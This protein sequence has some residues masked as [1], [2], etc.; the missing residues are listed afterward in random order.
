MLIPTMQNPC[1]L[2]RQRDISR[3][4]NRRGANRVGPGGPGARVLDRWTY[5]DRVK[6][7]FIEPGKPVQNCFVKSFNGAFRAEDLTASFCTIS[8]RQVF[9]MIVQGLKQILGRQ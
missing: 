4:I 9:V 3:V 2:P 5:E 8:E 6:L 7:E 1:K